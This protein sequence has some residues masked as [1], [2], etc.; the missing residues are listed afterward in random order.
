MSHENA[1]SKR[2]QKLA[3]S[4]SPGLVPPTG[5]AT[6]KFLGDSGTWQSLPATPPANAILKEVEV[7]FGVVPVSS[8]SFTIADTDVTAS[9]VIMATLGGNAVT[10]IAAQLSLGAFVITARAGAGQLTLCAFSLLGLITGKRKILYLIG[11]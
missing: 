10:G 8:A 3:T 6:G 7:D 2:F 9:K 5:G 4:A 11:S 1:W